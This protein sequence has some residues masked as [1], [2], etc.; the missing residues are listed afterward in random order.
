MTVRLTSLA[1]ALRAVED[2]HARGPV[3]DGPWAWSQLLEHCAQSIEC[4]LDGFPKKKPVV[5]QKTIG[6]WV[7][8]RF[9]KRGFIRHKRSAT[10]P[11]CA[12][13]P[14]GDEAAAL[15]RLRQAI[16]R[17]EA[18]DDPLQPHFVYG[19]LSKPDY[20]KLHAMHIA[21]HLEGCRSGDG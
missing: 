2:V 11:G 3:V 8:R 4:S 14:P 5:V 18:H 13:P 10:I 17:F 20:D 9:L 21:D 19:R 7:A 1:A 6:R 12:V 15:D 16:A